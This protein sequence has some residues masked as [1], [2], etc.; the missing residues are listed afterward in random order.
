MLR[1]RRGEW[2]LKRVQMALYMITSIILAFLDKDVLVIT[3]FL[4]ASIGNGYLA[5]KE[6]KDDNK[7]IRS[8][9]DER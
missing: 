3:A 9:H 4:G 5:G 7:P 6:Q 8:G 2:C 1:N